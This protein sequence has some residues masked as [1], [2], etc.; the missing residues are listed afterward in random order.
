MAKIR[1]PKGKYQHYKTKK[2]YEVLGGGLHTE[3]EEDLVIYK[4]LYKSEYE[5]FA[6]P[7]KMFLEK[8]TDPETGKKVSRFKKSKV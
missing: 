4:P 7:V 3:T 1:V 8:V 5:F 6:R 2:F